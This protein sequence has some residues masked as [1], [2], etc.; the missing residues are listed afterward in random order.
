M[1]RQW[2]RRL[3]VSF[4]VLVVVTG[5]AFAQHTVTTW[6]DNKAGVVSLTFDDGWPEHLSFAVPNMDARGFKGTLFLITG[7]V[8]D[9]GPWVAAA[10]SGHELGSHTV[11]HLFLTQIPPDAAKAEIEGSKAAIDFQLGSKECVSLAYPY[12]DFNTD[13]MA[14]ALS[15]GYIS[16]RAVG[17]WYNGALGDNLY[18]LYSCDPFYG[19]ISLDQMKAWTEAAA[20]RGQ[21]LVTLFHCLDGRCGWQQSEFIAYL[22]YLKGKNVWVAPQGSVVKY[23]KERMA[24]SLYVISATSDRIVLTLTARRLDPAVYDEPLTIRSEVPS[25]WTKVTVSQGSVETTVVPVNEGGTMVVYYNAIPDGSYIFLTN[26]GYLV[27]VVT[28]LSPSSANVGSSGFY[29]TVYGKNFV[30]GAIVRWNQMN[31]RTTF[32]SDTQLRAWVM[33]SDLTKAG[34]ASVWVTNPAPGG[35]DSNKV[36]FTIKGAAPSVIDYIYPAYRPWSLFLDPATYNVLNFANTRVLPAQAD[37][38]YVPADASSPGWVNGLA[39]QHGYVIKLPSP[40]GNRFP[41]VQNLSPISGVSG[42]LVFVSDPS[43]KLP[44]GSWWL[45]PVFLANPNVRAVAGFIPGLGTVGVWEK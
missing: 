20:Q 7:N 15:A 6:R 13:I 4:V 1:I 36:T 2:M 40:T 34:T 8:L 10:N 11:N 14:L 22:D 5:S 37:T 33:P 41:A 16:A 44:S 32:I 12:S 38:L 3:A 24:A 25:G 42:V 18:N 9:W 39:G 19:G 28:T 31:R 17:C 35:G 29:I 21:W 45:D 26:A 30:S 27:P 23:I 43:L